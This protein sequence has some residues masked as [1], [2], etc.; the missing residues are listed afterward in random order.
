[1]YYPFHLDRYTVRYDEAT[2]TFEVLC[3]G[4]VATDPQEGLPL[5]KIPT[6]A[7]AQRIADRLKAF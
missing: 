6:R 7:R 3:N 2:N 4:T 1:M 5:D